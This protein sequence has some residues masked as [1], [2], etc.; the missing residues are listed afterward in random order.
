MTMQA[1]K[2]LTR[3]TMLGGAL[4]L[5]GGAVVAA[6]APFASVTTT[7]SAPAEPAKATS[8]SASALKNIVETDSGRISGFAR[9]GVVGFRGIPYATSTEGANRF[10]PPQK[11]KPW[12]GVRSALYWGWTS[13][14]VYNSSISG[15]RVGWTHDDEAFMFEWEDGQ[16]SE[17]CLRLNVWTPA[18]DN[19]K[20]A[21]M[22]WIH[23]GGMTTGSCYELHSYEGENLARQ[24]DVVVVSINHRLAVLGFLNLS[25]YGDQYA[26]SGNASMLDIIA[27]LQWVQTN[28]ANFGGD[29]G[30]V[31][32]FGQSGGG[33]KVGTIMGMPA[34]KGLYHRASIQS[35]SHLLQ[36][37]MDSSQA[38]AHATLSE[39]GI[40]KKNIGKLHTDFT[41]Q[42]IVEA[43]IVG[44]GDALAGSAPS[45]VDRRP[46]W[47]P[48]VDGHLIPRDTWGQAAPDP[49][50]DVPLIVGTVLNESY[51]SVQMGDAT[52]ESMDMAEARRRLK[53]IVGAGTDHAVEVAQKLYPKATPFE[54][55]SLT[56]AMKQRLNACK[57]AEMKTKQG[58]APAY[59]LS[60]RVAITDVRRAGSRISHQRTP[61][62]LPQRGAM[63]QANR[64][65]A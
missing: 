62:L 61:V 9:D 60:L 37:T 22:F 42:Q 58:G 31:M 18:L 2:H 65:H 24:Q 5:G 23:G 44:Q 52:L 54:I 20:R 56:G 15:R 50:A 40:S 8:I 7:T 33:A 51:N 16:P 55:F 6:A 14:S 63:R 28:I 49:S 53:P 30:R 46:G 3:R 57:Q 4:K 1:N 39:L 64:Q 13:P 34:A 10:M 11:L 26:A 59:P 36:S 41:F 43:G 29:P 48:V 35:G 32:M 12:T 17:D 25:E 27:A 38:L 21:V 19:K 47:G 45:P